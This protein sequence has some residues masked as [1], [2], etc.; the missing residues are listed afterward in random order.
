MLKTIIFNYRKNTVK[1]IRSF[2]FIAIA[3]I[4]LIKFL[5]INNKNLYINFFSIIILMSTNLI[6]N[7]NTNIQN[8]KCLYQSQNINN[9][10]IFDYNFLPNINPTENSRNSYIQSTNIVGVLQNSNY[11]ISG[12]NINNSTLLRNGELQNLE[13]KKELDTR[14]F[15]GS[16]FMGSGQS[17]LK[18]TDLSS[19]LKFGEDTRTSKSSNALSSY[20]ADNFIPL[21]PSIAENIQNVDHIIPT[22]WI[23]GGMSSRS[24]VRNIDYMK[25]CGFT[26]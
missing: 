9:E 4:F 5:F 21:V 13:P 26:K 6:I 22:Y 1:S 25:S 23:R 11:D 14:I 24:V 20:S 3:N 8:E 7:Q 2:T 17:V 18:N 12:K 10:R 16:P 15:P 19:R